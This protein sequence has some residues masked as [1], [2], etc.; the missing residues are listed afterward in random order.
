MLAFL[1]KLLNIVTIFYIVRLCSFQIKSNRIYLKHKIW[2][3]K[4]DEKQAVNQMGTKTKTKS[5]NRTQ[6]QK[7]CSNVSPKKNKKASIR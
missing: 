6:R 2:K 3:K 4:G 1:Y 5:A 7:D